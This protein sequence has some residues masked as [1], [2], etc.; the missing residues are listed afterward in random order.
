MTME[1]SPEPNSNT[2]NAFLVL[3][4]RCKRARSSAIGGN[5]MFNLPLTASNAPSL[6]SAFAS[7]LMYCLSL[8]V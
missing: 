3:I 7:R 6:K 2:V 1:D 4:S 5:G 8:L